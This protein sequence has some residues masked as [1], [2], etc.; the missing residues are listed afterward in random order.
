MATSAI[1]SGR[2]SKFF[3]YTAF[4]YL[5]ELLKQNSPQEA[6]QSKGCSC[7]SSRSHLGDRN[8]MY[9]LIQNM[10]T[11]GESMGRNRNS[12]IMMN[13]ENKDKKS[14]FTAL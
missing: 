7:K 9:Y 8:Y 6:K 3:Q 4:P 5:M 1:F 12:N 14:E 11:D 2:T 10:K 13:S